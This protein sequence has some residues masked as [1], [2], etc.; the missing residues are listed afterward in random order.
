[1][2][3]TSRAAGG[4]PASLL[5]LPQDVAAQIAG[6]PRH[7]L[8]DHPELRGRNLDGTWNLIELVQGLC[9]DYR[10]AKLNDDELEVVLRAV[11]DMTVEVPTK[12]VDDIERVA[13]RHGAAGLAAIGTV[14]LDELKRWR[15][16]STRWEEAG[17]LRDPGETERSEAIASGQTIACCVH[18]GK[19]R[20]GSK[21]RKKPERSGLVELETV[22]PDCHA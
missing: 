17:V 6:V 14:V 22:C 11:E 13:A 10:P 18:C 2:A 9:T 4:K 16:T 8:K 3:K 15:C 1:M 19:Y 12:L 20:W 5:R 21:W 7:K